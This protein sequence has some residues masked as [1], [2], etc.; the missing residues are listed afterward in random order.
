MRLRYEF[1]IWLAVVGRSIE[2]ERALWSIAVYVRCSI[3][4]CICDGC[5]P[6]HSA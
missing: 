2:E 3:L 4:V 6:K 5:V 1:A